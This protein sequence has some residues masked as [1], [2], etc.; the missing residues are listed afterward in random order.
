MPIYSN[1]SDSRVAGWTQSRP[2]VFRLEDM[3]IGELIGQG[4]YGN[5]YK[6]RRH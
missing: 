5:V 3:E 2:R 1:A 6:V 4:F